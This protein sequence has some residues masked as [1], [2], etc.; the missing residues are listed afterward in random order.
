MVAGNY[1]KAGKELWQSTC[2]LATSV[3][4]EHDY[5]NRTSKCY[6]FRGL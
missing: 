3:E 2:M 1:G 4:E 5:D 6:Y